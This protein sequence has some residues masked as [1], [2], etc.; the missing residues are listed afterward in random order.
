M[1]KIKCFL[2]AIFAFVLCLSFAGCAKEGSMMQNSLQYYCIYYSSLN[3]ITANYSFK[4]T[5]PAAKNYEVNYNVAVY[6]N[7]RLIVSKQQTR[8]VS[9][10]GNDSVSVSEYW[11]IPYSGSAVNE[12]ALKVVVTDVRVTQ[13]KSDNSYIGYAVGFGLAGG[14]LLIAATVLFVMTKRKNDVPLV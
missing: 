14:A 1:K 10:N 13:Q 6:E 3:Q 11:D 7:N 4:V 12:S 2:V 8:T 9:P 5:I